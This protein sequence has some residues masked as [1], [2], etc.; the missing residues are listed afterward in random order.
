MKSQAA[1]GLAAL[2]D[3]LVDEPQSGIRRSEVIRAGSQ[4]RQN[5]PVLGITLAKV[6]G[7]CD[8]HNTLLALRFLRSSP[9]AES[10]VIGH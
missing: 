4:A 5:P 7:L 3:L 1:K 8:N 6:S 10:F 9:L 2:R